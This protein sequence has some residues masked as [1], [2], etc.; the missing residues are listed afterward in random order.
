M[1]KLKYILLLLG[2]TVQ[3]QFTVLTG[4]IGSQVNGSI[5]YSISSLSYDTNAYSASEGS[6]E[7]VGVWGT[8]MYLGTLGDAYRYTLDDTDVSSSTYDTNTSPNG[9]FRN[10]LKLSTSGLNIIGA[11]FGGI[12]YNV[13]LSTA[14]DLSSYGTSVN[15]NISSTVGTNA[16]GWAINSSGTKLYVINST[17]DVIYQYSISPAWTGVP[18]Y[19]SVNIDIT[20]SGI[21]DPRGMMLSPDDGLLLIIDTT[22][23]TIRQ[24]SFGTIDNIST[25]T[26]DS[27]NVSTGANLY[28]LSYN[29]DNTKILGLVFAGDVRQYSY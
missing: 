22:N 17:T 23:D 25:L 9:A 27:I 11:A 4:V 21:G 10:M 2:I 1:N 7:G 14:G 24:Y 13:P 5:D 6:M 8:K 15:T 19:D 16:R 20:A 26:Y 3:A 12:M 28:T 18:S 29:N